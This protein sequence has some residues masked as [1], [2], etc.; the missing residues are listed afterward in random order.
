MR[1][2]ELQEPIASCYNEGAQLSRE[3]YLLPDNIESE[4][5]ESKLQYRKSSVQKLMEEAEELLKTK[6]L[7]NNCQWSNPADEQRFEF[8]LQSAGDGWNE[9]AQALLRQTG[10]YCAFCEVPLG[11]RFSVIHLLP[12]K[13]FPTEAF[14][15]SNLLPACP[16]CAAVKADRPG[17]DLLQQNSATAKDRILNPHEFAWPSRYWENLSDGAE[18]PYRYDLYELDAATDS[19]PSGRLIMPDEYPALIEAWRE[20]RLSEKAGVFEWLRE[21]EPTTWVAA[22]MNPFG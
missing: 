11:P 4:N 10:H 20:G 13:L 16:I 12:P 1:P 9:A 15:F 18:F 21:E 17:Q 22:L 6:W 2:L 14:E 7:D 5:S 8:T 19:V 3:I